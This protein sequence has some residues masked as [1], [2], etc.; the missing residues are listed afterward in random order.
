MG[1]KSL[2]VLFV[3]AEVAPFSTVGGLA[4]VSYFLPRALKKMGVDVRVFTPKYGSINSALLR[5]Q[6]VLQGLK[7]PTGEEGPEHPHELICN[8]KTNSI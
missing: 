8:V 4:Q 2:K 7:V 1:S 3:T 5:T 6:N